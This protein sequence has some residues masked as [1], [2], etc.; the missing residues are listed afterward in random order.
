VMQI[1]GNAEQQASNV[2]AMRTLR[3]GSTFP[4]MW[5]SRCLTLA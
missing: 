3:I 4:I 1:V 5:H 2:V